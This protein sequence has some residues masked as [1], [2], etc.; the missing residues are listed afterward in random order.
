MGSAISQV[1]GMGGV[2]LWNGGMVEWPSISDVF[3]EHP[4]SLGYCLWTSHQWV[5]SLT[6][7][8]MLQIRK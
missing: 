6:V 2:E 8:L 4:P 5:I 1:G 3:H 7:Q